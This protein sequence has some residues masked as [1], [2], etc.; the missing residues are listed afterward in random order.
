LVTTHLALKVT[1]ALVLFGTAVNGV[2]LRA[3]E[4]Q[5]PSSTA[6]LAS[7]SEVPVAAGVASASVSASALPEDPSALLAQQGSGQA[8]KAYGRAGME[9]APLLA[10]VIKP[11][12]QAQPLSFGQKEK[13]VFV[14][15]F[16]LESL[17]GIILSAAYS[18]ITN[19]QPNYGT[20]ARAFGQR[21]GAT[22]VRDT[23][24]ELFSDA[25]LAPILHQDPRYY[26]LGSGHNLVRR[27]GYAVT[28]TLITRTDGGRQTVN[29]SLLGGYAG[30]SALSMTY[31]PQSNRNFHDAASSYGG[32][33]AGE[34]LY[35][36]FSEFF[37]SAF[38]V[39]RFRTA[40]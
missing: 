33:I 7:N 15:T 18:D 27:A 12:L 11:Q 40:K 5:Q 28:R 13:V 6:L 16:S 20:N 26:R 34:A 31:Y 35:Y 21:V 38:D 8:S 22:A 2:G 39:V 37:D 32:S 10:M 24:E 23:S 4:L 19:G 17:G 9:Q 30:A 29:V 36:L 3:Q 1:V 14:D 25:V